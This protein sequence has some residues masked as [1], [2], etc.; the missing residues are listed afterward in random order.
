MKNLSQWT[1]A[2]EDVSPKITKIL[3]RYPKKVFNLLSTVYVDIYSTV[4]LAAD[5]IRLH[6]KKCFHFIDPNF[7]QIAV[8]EIDEVAAFCIAIPSLAH[9]AQK[10]KRR[11]FPFGLVHILH[12]LNNPRR[13]D[14]LRM[15]I[16]PDLQT[17]GIP[18]ILISEGYPE[19]K[20]M[21]H[22]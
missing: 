10:A 9:A 3:L 5:Q 18:S 17:R 1:Q 16:H 12:A 4:G 8:K 15:A 13:K 11:I 2:I 19:G 6:I 7:A 22:H 21:R 20:K 14:T